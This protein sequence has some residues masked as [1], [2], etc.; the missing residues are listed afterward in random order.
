MVEKKRMEMADVGTND[1]LG[2]VEVESLIAG[3]ESL[4]LSDCYHWSLCLGGCRNAKRYR[5]G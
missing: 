3:T 1:M 5:N 2:D 4:E